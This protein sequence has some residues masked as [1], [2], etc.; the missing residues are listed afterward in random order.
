[1]CTSLRWALFAFIPLSHMLSGSWFFSCLTLFLLLLFVY[2]F[3][4]FQ[5]CVCHKY[6][7][8]K[9]FS[10]A[11][12]ER[13]SVFSHEYFELRSHKSKQRN[14]TSSLVLLG[15]LFR[16]TTQWYGCHCPTCA[17]CWFKL[18]VV[19]HWIAGSSAKKNF[20]K[21]LYPVHVCFI[22]PSFIIIIFFCFK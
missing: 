3:V 1:M 12:C 11:V 6:V 7:Y 17:A 8:V 2:L 5:K 10:H 15:W 21:E 22:F 13:F 19:C 16:C 20:V 9:R 18:C 14:L 4:Y